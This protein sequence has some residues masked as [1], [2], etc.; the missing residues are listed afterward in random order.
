MGSESR[1]M[2]ENY[3]IRD[4]EVLGFIVVLMVSILSFD[5]FA[6]AQDDLEA[7]KDSYFQQ[8]RYSEFVQYLS[9]QK[10]ASPGLTTKISYYIALSRYQQLKYLEETQSWDEYFNSGNSYRDELTS[11]IDKVI[12]ATTPQDKLHI[13]ALCLSWRFH[14]DQN[15]GFEDKARNDLVNAV[16]E[17]AKQN[18]E[19]EVVKYVADVFSDYKNSN[20]ARRLYNIYAKKLVESETDIEKLKQAAQDAY[21]RGN[22]SLAALIYDAYIT[23][24][25]ELYPKDKLIAELISIL[26]QFAYNDQGSFDLEFANKLF[27]KLEEIAGSRVFDERLSYARAYNLE[28][29]GEF[30]QA[31]EQYLY[32]IENFKES[33]FYHEALFKIGLFYA[34]AI[35]DIEKSRFYLEKL[36]SGPSVNAQ[37][38]SG[39]YQ[40]GL[41]SQWSGDFN[42]AKEYY[43]E[44]LERSSDDFPEIQILA[45]E[46][47]EEIKERS[48]RIEYNLK[49][50]A[51]LSL[52]E[53]RQASLSFRQID[54][55]ATPLKLKKGQTTEIRASSYL[56]ST[57]CLAVEIK[58]LWSGDLGETLPSIE[59]AGF[60]TFYSSCGTKMINL[61]VVTPTGIIGSGFII[62]EVE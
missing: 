60:F 41:L 48:G 52:S 23:K 24:I 54:L 50:F 21:R 31:I 53:L 56:P 27:A 2:K 29:A 15:D 43:L 20:Q 44:L 42:K 34:Y 13:Y 37:V 61:V 1:T 19:S 3:K 5:L 25:I 47:L 62:L 45:K 8:H 14:K 46:R 55:S 30:P 17:Y 40:L 18:P 9:R 39:F 57:G 6:F 4:F 22:L 12:N 7:L 33:K 32:L 11:Q 26:N 59:Q 28:K 10:K 51:D 49:T 16:I 36:I 38:I 35:R 58:Y